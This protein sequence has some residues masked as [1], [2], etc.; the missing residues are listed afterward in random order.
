MNAIIDIA[1]IDDAAEKIGPIYFLQPL[2]PFHRILTVEEHIELRLLPQ[3]LVES[4][5]NTVDLVAELLSTLLEQAQVI[6][7]NIEFFEQRLNGKRLRHVHPL[8]RAQYGTARV[9]LPLAALT[10]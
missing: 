1:L 6:G 7:P 4:I 10:A 8:D 2:D 9:K 3:P 5:D